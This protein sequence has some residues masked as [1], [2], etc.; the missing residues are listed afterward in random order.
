MDACCGAVASTGPTEPSLGIESS[1]RATGNAL[2]CSETPPTTLH[3]ASMPKNP[4]V[5]CNF[6]S[7]ALMKGIRS[8]SSAT[9]RKGHC[10]KTCE[11]LSSAGSVAGGEAR[12][13]SVA[14]RPGGPRRP[15]MQLF[16]ARHTECDC[17]IV[18]CL[19]RLGHSDR[20]R[21]RIRRKQRSFLTLWLWILAEGL[22]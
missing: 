8:R 16:G 1:I 13:V 7:P 20:L 3:D 9:I 19:A 4:Y 10:A 12:R 18:L 11:W 21:I 17:S 5:I 14:P 6:H 15:K 2:Q 22:S